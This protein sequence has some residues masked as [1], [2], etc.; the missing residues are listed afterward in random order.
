MGWRPRSARG[1]LRSDMVMARLNAHLLIAQPWAQ[2]SAPLPRARVAG[3]PRVWSPLFNARVLDPRL[4]HRRLPN[5]R[6]CNFRF[7]WAACLLSGLLLHGCSSAP[8]R[9]PAHSGAPPVLIGNEIAL[10]AMALLGAPYR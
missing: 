2:P 4:P 1:I 7:S 8:P 5:S 9:P 10:R 6:L 3:A